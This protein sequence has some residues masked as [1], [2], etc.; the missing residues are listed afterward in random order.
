[1]KPT[2][3]CF[4]A[5]IAQK[6]FMTTNLFPEPPNTSC[7]RSWQFPSKYTKYDYKHIFS[8]HNLKKQGKYNLLHVLSLNHPKYWYH[9]TVRTI[10]LIARI[11]WLI[12][13]F[14]MMNLWGHSMLHCLKPN[15]TSSM[16]ERERWERVCLCCHLISI[17]TKYTKSY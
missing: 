15:L 8:F 1:M 5:F 3:L 9:V 11:T 6:S 13:V 2:W 10:L 4:Y 16:R 12:A 17:H 7:M 14:T